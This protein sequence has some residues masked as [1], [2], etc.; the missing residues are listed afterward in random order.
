MLRKYSKY[1]VLIVAMLISNY[2]VFSFC[3][4]DMPVNLCL[5]IQSDRV[6]SFQIFYSE[7]A[8]FT[9]EQSLRYDYTVAETKYGIEQILPEYT[10]Y[11]RIDLGEQPIGT[12]HLSDI[13]VTYYGGSFSLDKERLLAGANASVTATLSDNSLF[14]QITGT[15]P[16]LSYEF[17][18][19]EQ[20]MLATQKQKI[21][22]LIDITICLLI[23]IFL[24]LM[25]RKATSIKIL[26]SDIYNNRTL[27]WRLAVNDFKTK[28]TGSYL[29]L[30][31]AFVQPVITIV[32]YWIVFQYGL[33]VALPIIEVPFAVWLIAG[34]VP[35]FFFAEALSN[36][37][38]SMLE[39]SYLVKKIVFKVSILPMVKILSSLFIHLIFVIFLAV[40]CIIFVGKPSL[41]VIQFI[42]YT[43]CAF[44][45]VLALSYITSSIMVFFR[46]LNQ[47]IAILLQIGMWANPILWHISMASDKYRWIF[48]ISPI[49][50]VIDGY[51]D[52]FIFNHWFWE[53]PFLTLWFWAFCAIC[54]GVGS[55][56][57]KRLKPHFA[58]V[59]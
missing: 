8:D 32:L 49:Y 41:Q 57:F 3:K 35:W 38:N 30:T 42:Y 48:E 31:W 4:I 54:L 17:I 11:I 15:D 37:T 22:N 26:S 44:A 19:T 53:K 43:I 52:A 13:Q 6:D 18:E 14:A 10:K 2:A 9:E 36:A 47:I 46:D 12:V 56:V 23:D 25:V 5:N 16:Y 40:L 24:A 50:Y 27:I 20:E 45:L 21:N 59:L 55:I 34:M 58:D 1:I 7:N 33:R 28:Y 29:G 39:Y 51:R